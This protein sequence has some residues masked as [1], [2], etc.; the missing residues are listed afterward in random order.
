MAKC[1][2]NKDAE[3]QICWNHASA[4]CSPVSL[5]C[6]FGTPYHR[7]VSEGLL[8]IHHGLQ[9]HCIIQIHRIINVN[10]CMKGSDD[11]QSSSTGPFLANIIVKK[12]CK[13][14]AEERKKKNMQFYII[15]KMLLYVCFPFLRWV[16]FCSGCFRQV[17]FHLGDKSGRWSL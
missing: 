7:M 5:L 1:D 2:F 6:V 10:I 16:K 12:L 9:I 3:Q 14:F 13:I 8:S 11:R 15:L 17:F 4:R